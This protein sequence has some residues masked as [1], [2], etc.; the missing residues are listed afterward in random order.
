MILTIVFITSYISLT[1]WIFQKRTLQFVQSLSV[2]AGKPAMIP[3]DQQ[4]VFSE[5]VNVL[6]KNWSC[7]SQIPFVLFFPFFRSQISFILVIILRA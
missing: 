2:L 6:G 1:S 3:L 7:P 4:N 5:Y